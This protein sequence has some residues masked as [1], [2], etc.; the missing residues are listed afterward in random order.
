MAR[1]PLDESLVTELWLIT[2]AVGR[3]N[4]DRIANAAM[5]GHDRSRERC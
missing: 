5:L 1:I 3:E 4:F 2:D